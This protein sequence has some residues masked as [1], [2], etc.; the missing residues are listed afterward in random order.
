MSVEATLLRLGGSIAKSAGAAWLRTRR[1]DAERR[2]SLVELVGARGLGLVPQRRLVRQL[3]QLAETVAERLQP[4][5]LAEF[6]RLDDNE[7]VAALNGVAQAIE[8]ADLSDVR[9]LGAG[10]SSTAVERLVGPSAATVRRQLG[11]SEAGEGFFDLV[12]REVI[13]YLTEV[14]STLPSFQGRALSELLERD[15]EIIDHLREI[16]DRMPERGALSP[17]D[18]TAEFELE[19]LREVSRKLDQVELFGVTTS[20]P[21]RR[22]PLSVAYVGL[23]TSTG[24]PDSDD[25][26]DE[27]VEAALAGSPRTLIRGEAGSGKTTLLRWLAVK[28]AQGSLESSLSS[29][30]GLVPFF[31]Q[32]RGYADR[33]LPTPGELLSTVAWQLKDHM[34][35]RWAWDVLSSGR[36]LVLVDGVDEVP[37][38]DRG[39]V[40]EW[41]S[42]LVGAFPKSRYVVTSRPPAIP[43]DWLDDDGFTAAALQPMSRSHIRAFVRHWHDAIRVDSP[44][45]DQPDL[46]A[47]QGSLL[48][49]IDGNQALRLLVTNPLLCA[50]V[51]AL[52]HDRRSQLPRG[53]MDLYR[54]A[55][56]ML[57]SRRDTERR[58]PGEAHVALSPSE[59]MLLL[60][61]LA[62]WY[63]LN[64]LANATRERVVNRLA[65]CL[66]QMPGKDLDAAHVYSHL[67]LR[68]GLL[69]EY[70]AGQVDFVHKTFQEYLA[71]KRIVE[72][73]SI[74][75]LVNHAHEDSYREVIIMAVGH[76]RQR[77]REQLLTEI[78][79][80]SKKP[81]LPAQGRKALQLL[82]IACLETTTQL[83]PEVHKEIIGCLREVIP[84]RTPGEARILATMGDE[85]LPLLRTSGQL[86]EAEAA[87]TVQTAGLVAGPRALPVLAALAHDERGPVQRELVRM[88]SY[89]DP[90]QY[91]RE[92]LAT[93]PLPGGDLHIT[94]PR[95]LPGVPLVPRVVTLA[96]DFTGSLSDNEEHLLATNEK[97]QALWLTDNPGLKSFAFLHGHQHLAD[98]EVR[99][100]PELSDISAI[101]SM[102]ALRSITFESCPGVAE[103]DS[104]LECGELESLSGE[105]YTLKEAKA[106]LAGLKK[107]RS[108]GIRRCPAMHTLA[109]LGAHDKL[110][111]L[112]LDAC[113]E[114][115]NLAGLDNLPALTKL[116]FMDCPELSIA[117][118]HLAASSLRSLSLRWCGEVRDLKPLSE[119]RELR[120][121]YLQGLTIDSLKPL[122]GLKELD[123]LAVV[124]CEWI[125][126]LSPLA[127]LPSLRHLSLQRTGHRLDLGQL[128]A[129]QDLVVVHSGNAY[130]GNALGA[131]MVSSTERIPD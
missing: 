116:T 40:R 8:A 120:W 36:A 61:D 63:T 100:A 26:D 95:V 15:N 131:V 85:V 4:L 83:S 6:R 64:Q 105:N 59:K 52:N 35:P 80:A 28:C 49:A 92:V 94:D 51:C 33:R 122:A 54:T 19:Y 124:D 99:N 75:M 79:A 97:L 70:S 65:A 30:N 14:I 45:G 93:A 11:L 3:E 57:L 10:V 20:R 46:T 118:P 125:D 88:W 55:L 84:P 127:D 67:L 109:D 27:T 29:W 90:E 1:S 68:S 71:A 53:R 130:N 41:L 106:L 89:F 47:Y 25:E 115:S 43:D 37:E 38:R 32:L 60:E 72:T 129:K 56:D 50:L 102:S 21:T 96:G 5:V 22:Y 104:L 77:E 31:V 81:G 12:L 76:A 108:F 66:R 24:A 113:G 87:A 13:A 101:T 34:P 110:Q 114:L 2:M 7:R 121:L 18:N 98:L 17:T 112:T 62:H 39:A 78:L 58:I 123:T 126:D 128:G 119:M 44:T 16:L 23:M 74:E 107:L 73:D 103:I 82:T 9:V 86:S 42:D 117:G 69:R 91:A 111:G 48:A